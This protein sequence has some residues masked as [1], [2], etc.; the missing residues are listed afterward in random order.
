MRDYPW[1]LRLPTTQQYQWFKNLVDLHELTREWL[2]EIQTDRPAHL[3][4]RGLSPEVSEN[5]WM[6]DSLSQTEMER[7]LDD[8]SPDDTLSRL[9][10]TVWA[11]QSWT[12]THIYGRATP[13]NKNV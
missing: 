13:S 8:T 2:K 10:H 1:H 6:L 7:L 12:L 9:E 11:V 5:L 3:L 4:T